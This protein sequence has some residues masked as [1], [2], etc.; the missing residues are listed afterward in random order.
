[1]KQYLK[2]FI[3]TMWKPLIVAG[4]AVGG[5]VYSINNHYYVAMSAFGIVTSVVMCLWVPWLE[6]SFKMRH[7][8]S[9]KEAVVYAF[10][11]AFLYSYQIAWFGVGLFM[12]FR[13]P[14]MLL[15]AASGLCYYHYS[16]KRMKVFWYINHS[17]WNILAS[18]IPTWL[19][20]GATVNSI[21]PTLLTVA[22]MLFWGC[23]LACKIAR[24]KEVKVC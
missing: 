15:H 2:D 9:K 10:F 5:C 4:V 16:N 23:S 14:M 3:C 6:E 17:S 12:V 19:Y 18:V 22:L 7:C 13:L 21:R 1:M 24:K 8:S 20:T 11:E